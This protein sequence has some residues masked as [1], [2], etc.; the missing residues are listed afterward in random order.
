MIFLKSELSWWARYKLS[1]RLNTSIFDFLVTFLS[2]RICRHFKRRNSIYFSFRTKIQNF[3]PIFYCWNPQRV[4]FPKNKTIQWVLEWLVWF[5]HRTI[6]TTVHEA[7]LIAVDVQESSTI[8]SAVADVTHLLVLLISWGLLSNA[9]VSGLV[10]QS[11][12]RPILHKD[13]LW[14]DSRN[15]GGVL[16]IQFFK[17]TPLGSCVRNLGFEEVLVAHTSALVIRC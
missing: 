4:S 9:S 5:H 1:F 10:S 12:T 15:P 8:T 16:E 2:I 11:Y 6:I 17:A 13:F 3:A 7:Q 14:S